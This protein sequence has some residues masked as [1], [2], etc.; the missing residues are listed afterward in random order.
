[1]ENCQPLNYGIF[2]IQGCMVSILLMAK[3]KIMSG[4][5]KSVYP[6]V[7]IVFGFFPHIDFI[8]IFHSKKGLRKKIDSE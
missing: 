7:E 6:V 4:L 1:M 5:K 2:L 3:S 8:T